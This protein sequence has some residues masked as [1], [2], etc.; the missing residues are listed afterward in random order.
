[1][2]GQLPPNLNKNPQNYVNVNAFQD[3]LAL[4]QGLALLEIASSCTKIEQEIPGWLP[5]NKVNSNTKVVDFTMEV[6][7]NK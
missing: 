1:M 2:V 6:D 4:L 7:D 5:N 3:R